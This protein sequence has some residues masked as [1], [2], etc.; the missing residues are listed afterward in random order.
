MADGWRIGIG[1]DLHHA[2]SGHPL[3]LGGFEI[4][5]DFGLI[6]HQDGD[7]VLHEVIDALFGAAGLPEMSEHFPE[8]LQEL[9]HTLVYRHS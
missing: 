1:Y 6:G 4:R 5:N 7:M 9:S 3:L 2:A 8:D